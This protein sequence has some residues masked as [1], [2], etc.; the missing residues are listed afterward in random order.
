M[1]ND[2][3]AFYLRTI[4]AFN[5]KRGGIGGDHAIWM[6]GKEPVS[7]E[8]YNST[9][10]HSGG[11]VVSH[12]DTPYAATLRLFD[13]IV[14]SDNSNGIFYNKPESVKNF[15]TAEYKQ[16]ASGVDPQFTNSDSQWNGE[17]KNMDSLLYGKTKGYYFVGSS[18]TQTIN[19]APVPLYLN[20]LG[21]KKIKLPQLQSESKSYS[22]AVR[23]LDQYGNSITGST[24]TWSIV[25]APSGV[26]IDNNG[27]L[28]IP[29]MAA[30]NSSFTITA[31]GMSD[32]EVFGSSTITLTPKIN[33][34]F[35]I[36]VLTNL[37]DEVV[38]SL[39]PSGSVRAAVSITN[40]EDIA[41]EAELVIALYDKNGVLV[42][43]GSARGQVNVGESREFT[44]AI[45]LPTIIDG[46]YIEMFVVD[47]F[48]NMLP[49]SGRIK[50]QY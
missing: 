44:A 11:V 15:N 39:Q 27:T 8:A 28:T 12:E 6:N 30:P 26:S 7:L 2:H 48:E 46:H 34:T 35:G 18:I 1:W 24:I 41:M 40:T 17:G 49:L 16:S 47:S 21:E 33:M 5:F 45:G 3:T 25:G 50:L 23:L 13:C 10:I 32:V 9:F 36:P 31:K 43:L 19:S 38:T 4:S 14:V 37:N 20:I 22:Y 42:N 29:G